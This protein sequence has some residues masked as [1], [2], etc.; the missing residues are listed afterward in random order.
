MSNP[1]YYEFT[2]KIRCTQAAWSKILKLLSRWQDWDPPN[3]MIC[4][5]ETKKAGDS[6]RPMFNE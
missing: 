4:G 6:V 2:L 1:I 5:V 3:R